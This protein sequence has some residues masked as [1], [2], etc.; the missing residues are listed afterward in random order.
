MPATLVRVDVWS[1]AQDDPL[2]PAYGDAIAAMQ[3]KPSGDPT[4]WDYQAAIHGTEVASPLPQWKQRHRG[5][6]FFL[7]W[8]RMF[9][10]FFERIVRRVGRQR[11]AGRVGT[12]VLELRRG[13]R[14]KTSCRWRFAIPP[15]ATAHPT[16]SLRQTGHR[17]QRGLRSSG[18]GDD[19]VVCTQPA[20][21][22]RHDR[23]RWWCPIVRANLPN[24]F[25]F[26]ASAVPDCGWRSSRDKMTSP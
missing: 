10:Y 23:V 17:G 24:V 20:R 26:C 8:H 18:G 1:L 12:A 19:T 6:W 3:A 16:R 13:Q 4:S 2:L 21:L 9:L 11:R 5:D 7:S 22:H 25:V 14:P 15:E